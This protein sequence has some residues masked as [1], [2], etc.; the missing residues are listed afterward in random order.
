MNGNSTEVEDMA[1]GNNN[2]LSQLN[3]KKIKRIT[4]NR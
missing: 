2:Y 1:S 3:T 4:E